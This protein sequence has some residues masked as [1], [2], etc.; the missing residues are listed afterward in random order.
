ME[1]ELVGVLC[2]VKCGVSCF[3][4]MD[5]SIDMLV[6][7]K[8]L[9]GVVLVYL[10]EVGVFCLGSILGSI[11]G[12]YKYKSHVLHMRTQVLQSTKNTRTQM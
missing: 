3:L 5:C 9:M 12:V 7:W 11:K 8:K 4:S 6:S 2:N 10:S 1:L